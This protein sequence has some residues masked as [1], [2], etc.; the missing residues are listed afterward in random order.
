MGY[1]IRF[2]PTEEKMN[3]YKPWNG[4]E[5]E[6]RGKTIKNY[7]RDLISYCLKD[8]SDKSTVKIAET[9]E[10]NLRMLYGLIEQDEKYNAYKRWKEDE[11]HML[12]Y[13]GWEYSHNASY[14]LD[15]ITEST[16]DRLVILA[17][18]VK[19]PDYFDDGER[20]SEKWTEVSENVTGYTDMCR[21][22]VIHDII[23]DLKEFKDT[24][25]EKE[26]GLTNVVPT[27]Q[28]LDGSDAIQRE[29]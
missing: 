17:D 10:F 19:T 8:N 25:E 21:E 3:S 13:C 26:E 16:T 22:L 28:A 5:A 11:E 7:E 27:N 1:E 20:F 29:E 24:G 12:W 6:K 2:V 15:S 9:I 4:Y 14:D 23:D 18:V